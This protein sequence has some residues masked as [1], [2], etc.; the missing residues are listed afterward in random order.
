[1]LHAKTLTQRFDTYEKIAISN[2]KKRKITNFWICKLLIFQNGTFNLLVY[3]IR[4]MEQILFT[5]MYFS[6]VPK[7]DK[8]KVKKNPCSG[9]VS[10]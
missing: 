4:E 7:N 5:T 3:I 2:M 6:E 8:L 9:S 10:N 1:M